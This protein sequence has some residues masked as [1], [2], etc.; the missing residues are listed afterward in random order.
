MFDGKHKVVVASLN[1]YVTE[2][3]KRLIKQSDKIEQVVKQYTDKINDL[4]SRLNTQLSDLETRQ[5]SQLNE[6]YSQLSTFDNKQQV[7][8][9]KI[10]N[11]SGS[12]DTINNNLKQMSEAKIETISED[13]RILNKG[14]FQSKNQLGILREDVEDIATVNKSIA[15]LSARLDTM[16]DDKAA[17]ESRLHKQE[18]T[19]RHETSG[20]N[21]KI[22]N[23]NEKQ[24]I[25]DHKIDD[26][27]QRLEEFSTNFETFQKNFGRLREELG[28]EFLTERDQQI[29]NLTE[30]IR[31]LESSRAEINEDLNIV[32]KEK[33]EIQDLHLSL[34]RDFNN[35]KSNVEHD[36]V[37]NAHVRQV[38]RQTEQGK[39]LLE[40]MKVAPEKIK[41]EALSDRVGIA[42]VI[43]KQA[44][45]AMQEMRMLRYDPE[46]REIRLI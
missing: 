33:K 8:K 40:L 36:Y 6:I 14:L 44:V 34:E 5:N 32:R 25:I 2:L 10:S 17:F 31:Q 18:S 9:E 29:L 35:Y 28:K 42:L 11:L 43:I 22:I 24:V 1:E 23:L 21:Q 26:T 15:V 39:I 20:V 45:I 30:T 7:I 37:K 46:N 12:V 38:L 3:D 41:L 13:I 4:E 16:D 27:K 19:I